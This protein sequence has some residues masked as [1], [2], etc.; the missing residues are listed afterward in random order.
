M[1][2]TG[3]ALS[4]A[5]LTSQLLQT[6]WYRKSPF[7]TLELEPLLPHIPGTSF[8]SD[9]VTVAFVLA[10]SLFLL[11][12]RAGYAAFV[13][14]MCV[15]LAR[16]YCSLHWVSDVLGGALLGV[17]MRLVTARMSYTKVIR[18]PDRGILFI[19][20]LARLFACIWL[21]YYFRA[22]SPALGT[23]AFGI[24]TGK[25]FLP[26][27]LVYAGASAFFWQKQ[28]RHP[29][30]WSADPFYRKTNKSDVSKCQLV[31]QTQVLV[32]ALFFT[33]FYVLSL[34]VRSSLFVLYLIPLFSGLFFLDFSITLRIFVLITICFAAALGTITSLTRSLGGALS[35]INI[36]S[37]VGTVFLPK[38]LVLFALTV[39][40]G[41]QINRDKRWRSAVRTL[42]GSTALLNSLLDY[43]PL[44]IYRIDKQKRLIFVNKQ[45]C[46][47]ISMPSQ[48]VLGKRAAHLYPPDLVRIYDADDERVLNQGV[49]ISKD[50]EHEPPGKRRII[51][52]VIKTPIRDSSQQITGLQAVF[53]DVTAEK[54]EE[55]S[56]K[57]ERME[58]AQSIQKINLQLVETEDHL[59]ATE[60]RYRDIFQNASDIIYAHDLEGR[61]TSLN[62]AGE[63]IIGYYEPEFRKLN[64]FD[65]VVPEYHELIR[66]KMDQKIASQRG[67]HVPTTYEIEIQT[68]QGNRI[69][70]EIRSKVV[71]SLK[72]TVE[73]HG[74]A[75]VI[76]DRKEREK[77][78]A[79]TLHMWELLLREVH[80]RVRNNLNVI[81]KR[82]NEVDSSLRRPEI[83]HESLIDIV[84]SCRLRFI[85]MES[86]HGQLYKSADQSAVDMDGYLKLLISNLSTTYEGTPFAVK[87]RVAAGS[88][89]LNI[90]TANFCGIVATEL[91]SNSIEHA[92]PSGQPI[93]ISVELTREPDQAFVLL[94]SDSG[95]GM[96]PNKIWRSHSGLA[97]VRELVEWCGGSI[98]LLP[99]R[100]TVVRVRFEELKY[101][102][103]KG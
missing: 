30:W 62:K 64:V 38:A 70:L 36:P 65:V 34:D 48:E 45:Y 43:V 52:H 75:R 21:L 66:Q 39:A 92:F 31:L 18:E 29:E 44:N 37:L 16:V 14:A 32:D 49:V 78:T 15:G 83:D 5:F 51:V 8:P 76:T 93:D 41:W 10:T 3:L 13:L 98:D 71:L 89:K 77:E 91:V 79:R 23:P 50:E 53:W 47:T 103:T 42:S 54:A 22:P 97:L 33:I 28:R 59:R 95:V 80:H 55:E 7:V 82:L 60:S 11:S 25:L 24:S 96:E 84:R 74:I 81:S 63:E 1:V 2:E 88:I 56:L 27:W 102:D 90:D 19:A 9:H 40:F 68:K 87:A 26:V 61:F 85:A 4:V 17:A 20:N 6:F 58:L 86:L 67:E 100:G 12:R 35:D 72:Q 57:F 46:K 99:G 73:I 101:D 94:V 69:P